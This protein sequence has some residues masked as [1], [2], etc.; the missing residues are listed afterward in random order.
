MGIELGDMRPSQL[1]QEIKS[2]ATEDI[3]DKVLKTLWL[4]K[5]PDHIKNISGK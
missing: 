3:T 5:M 2:L 4:D 1:L